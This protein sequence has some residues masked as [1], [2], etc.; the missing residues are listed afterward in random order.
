MV[1]LRPEVVRIDHRPR[2]TLNTN[3]RASSHGT[4]LF[5][6]DALVLTP[7]KIIPYRFSNNFDLTSDG[8]IIEHTQRVKLA[9]MLQLRVNCSR[10]SVVNSYLV[11]TFLLSAI[12][13]W[14]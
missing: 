12:D 8:Y 14:G 2:Y 9:R 5:A 6:R 13:F 7:K 11:N 3:I 1:R 10:I 4:V